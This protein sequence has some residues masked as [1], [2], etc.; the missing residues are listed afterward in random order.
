ME[1]PD[2]LLDFLADGKWRSLNEVSA[3]NG[4]RHLNFMKLTILIGFLNEFGFIE[5][6]ETEITEMRAKPEV[7]E[8]WHSIREIEKSA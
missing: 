7:Q 6:S 8:F 3:A 1:A 2:A 5:V 4:L